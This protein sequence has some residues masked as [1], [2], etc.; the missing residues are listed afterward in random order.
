MLE[1]LINSVNYP[2]E[3]APE[4]V[5]EKPVEALT[6]LNDRIGLPQGPARVN[7]KNDEISVDDA[8]L[9]KKMVIKTVEDG[10]TTGKNRQQIADQL[11]SLTKDG[12]KPGD[13]MRI[14]Q[15]LTERGV[16]ETPAAEA[17]KE[18]PTLKEQ[19]DKATKLN[20]AAGDAFRNKLINQQQ[21][22]KIRSDYDRIKTEYQA[23]I[24]KAELNPIQQETIDIADKLEALGLKPFADGMRTSAEKNQVKEQNLEF[25]RTKLKQEQ[26]KQTT[27]EEGVERPSEKWNWNEFYG[28][29]TKGLDKLKLFNSKAPPAVKQVFQDISD[30]IQAVTDRLNDEGYV[31]RGASELNVPDEIKNLRSQIMLRSAEGSLLLNKFEALNKGFKRSKTTTNQQSLDTAIQEAKAGK[32]RHLWVLSDSPLQAVELLQREDPEIQVKLDDGSLDAWQSLMSMSNAN[33]FIGTSSKLSIWAIIFRALL[34]QE[35]PSYI[36]KEVKHHLVANLAETERS[37]VNFY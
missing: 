11:V 23:S 14:N 3:K 32:T 21:L 2:Q 13:F 12:I 30:S 8:V 34:L 33:I 28:D 19:Y 1:E 26:A 36:S 7:A 35:A 22:D 18:E 10:L 16:K 25:Y 31:M 29:D 20:F 9:L 27:L 4:V 24:P 15:Y 6:P 17:P 37:G 5:A